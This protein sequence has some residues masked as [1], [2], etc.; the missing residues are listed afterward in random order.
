MN[1]KKNE[2]RIREKGEQNERHRNNWKRA[3]KRREKKIVICGR[4]GRLYRGI[5]KKRQNVKRLGEWNLKRLGGRD[6]WD[7]GTAK[8]RNNKKTKKKENR[9]KWT[10]KEKT[11]NKRQIWK[12]QIVL[13]GRNGNR[14]RGGYPESW[15][16][17]KN[18]YIDR[19]ED[20]MR[21]PLENG[22]ANVWYEDTRKSLY[23]ADVDNITGE[24]RGTPHTG[25]ADTRDKWTQKRMRKKRKEER[26][27]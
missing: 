27:K 16:N 25:R 7:Q 14:D 10:K 1:R 13:C 18:P 21:W 3:E 19:W 20:W 8:R 6:T 4:R 26:E 11:K 2:R 12:I 5:S 24:F 9:E 17:G 22:R 23:V 15:Q